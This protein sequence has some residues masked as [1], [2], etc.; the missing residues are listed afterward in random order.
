MTWYKTGTVAVTAGSNAVIGS[1]TS[2]I[3]NSR[4]GDAFRGPDGEWYEVTNIASDTA[5]SIA[6]NYQGTTLAAGGY[7]LAPMQGYVKD[8]ADALR[9]A[10]QVIASGVADMQEQV[11]AATEAAATAVQA[12]AVAVAKADIATAAADLSTQ[13]KESTSQDATSAVQAAASAQAAAES[14]EEAEMATRGKAASG[15]NSDI[16]SLSG[17]TTALSVAQGGTGGTDQASAR[18]GLGFGTAATAKL[19]TSATDTT[20]GRALKVGDFGVGST[21]IPTL[22]DLNVFPGTG[23]YKFWSSAANNPAATFGTVQVAMYDATNWTQLVISTNSPGVVFTRSSVN[24]SI[25]PWVRQYI[26]TVTNA[27]GTAVKYPDGTMICYMTQTTVFTANQGY[28]SLFASAAAGFDYPATFIYPPA[29]TPSGASFAVATGWAT[30]EGFTST[31]FTGPMR[32]ISIAN[33]AQ[34][35][36]GY[37]AV[38]R[39]K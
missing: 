28:G 2:F 24:G 11:T 8:S 29:V 6:P 3:A 9:A 39:W 31:T 21:T 17:L 4:V 27:N 14:A 22:S 7:S 5:L 18:T 30:F 10:T 34:G 38:G 25:Q 33:G 13:N 20:A 16:T 12:E 23:H 32:W 35:R 37:I 1:G 26:E 19:T 36:I 15:A